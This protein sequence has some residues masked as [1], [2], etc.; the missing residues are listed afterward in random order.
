MNYLLL[1]KKDWDIIGNFVLNISFYSFLRIYLRSYVVGTCEKWICLPHQALCCT[2][3]LRPILI[4]NPKQ[5][6]YFRSHRNQESFIGVIEIKNSFNDFMRKTIMFLFQIQHSF[7]KLF[8]TVS[9]S[10]TI[11]CENLLFTDYLL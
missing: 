2:S 7:Q 10:F 5:I 9:N 1:F 8:F 4:M 11:D 3:C 6:Q